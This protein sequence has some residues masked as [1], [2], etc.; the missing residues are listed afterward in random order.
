MNKRKRR[1]LKLGEFKYK[2]PVILK[3]DIKRVGDSLIIQ[4][5]IASHAMTKKDGHNWSRTYTLP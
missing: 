4:T 5:K 1:K 2:A 3:Q